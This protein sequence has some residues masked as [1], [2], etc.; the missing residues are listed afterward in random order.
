MLIP[1]NCQDLLWIHCPWISINCYIVQP[2]LNSTNLIHKYCQIIVQFVSYLIYQLSV[3]IYVILLL[4][5]ICYLSILQQ[6]FYPS[7]YWTNLT[8]EILIFPIYWSYYY[9]FNICH[10]FVVDQLNTIYQV[11]RNSLCLLSLDLL[12]IILLM[13]QLHL[14]I[15]WMLILVYVIPSS[16]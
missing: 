4:W 11:L 5:L 1:F 10:Q 3:L 15:D 9:Y 8:L 6:L 12:V 16:H 13:L 2:L 14:K 7:P